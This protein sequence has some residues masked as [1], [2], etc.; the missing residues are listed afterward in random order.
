LAKHLF[1]LTNNQL[2]AMVW[3]NGEFTAPETF[4][5][6]PTGWQKFSD[7]LLE[8]NQ[9]PALFLTDLIE[10]DFQRESIP[11]VLGSARSNLVERRLNTLYRDTPYHKASFQDREKQGRRDDRVL[12]S[13]LTN[14]PLLTPWIDAVQANKVEL[15]GIYSVA[16]LT[17]LLFQKLNLVKLSSLVVTHQSSGLRQSF[18]Q[19]GYLRFSRLSPETAWSPESIAETTDTEMAKTRQ[20]LAS[21]RLLARGDPLQV[22]VIAKPE[23]LGFLAPRCLNG[24]G[25]QYRFITLQDAKPLFGVSKPIELNNC[26]SLFLSLLSSNRIV[27]HYATALQ[28]RLYAL[29]QV[30]SILYASC[31]VT[32]FA[33]LFLSAKDG[34][35]AINATNATQLARLQTRTALV[36]YQATVSNM[37]VTV[38]NPSDMRAAVEI[39]QLIS[40]NRPT[41]I[42]LITQISNAL[43]TFPLVKLTELK[44]DAS[45]SS[46]ASS[47]PNLAPPAEATGELVPIMAGLFGI[48]NKP[49]ESILLEAEITP[50]K[51]DYRSALNVVQ[52]FVTLLEKNPR[53]KVEIIKPPIDIRPTVKLESQ[54][55]NDDALKRPQFTLKIVWKP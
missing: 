18:F 27:S 26:D 51:N 39:E 1:Y 21:T 48:P 37:P 35:D 11:H 22:V 30:R 28:A 47:D 4:D 19:D 45:D 49:Q 5:N 13:A 29:S 14:V 38:A 32:V 34:I 46:A 42:T 15:A 16:L 52:Q 50:F 8:N 31:I 55:G 10:E 6:Y 53:I 54:S 41:P 3:D 44:W 2:T 9:I 12:F 20:F 36:N 25:L 7:Y 33:S 23:I 40:K 43:D 17:P 24:D